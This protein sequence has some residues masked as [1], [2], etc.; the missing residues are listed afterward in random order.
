M[1][2]REH[3][4]AKG[5]PLATKTL[6]PLSDYLGHSF[7]PDCDY[8]DGELQERNLGELDHSDLQTRLIELLL[9]AGNKTHIRANSELRMQVKPT[10]FRIPD[11]CVLRRDAPREQIVRTPPILCIEVLSPDDTVKKTREQVRDFLEM[12]VREV[13]I[14]DPA[15]HTATLCSGS[16]ATEQTGGVLRIPDLPIEF[17]LAEIFSVLDE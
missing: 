14:L 2:R 8:I 6:I 7:R 11:V 17:S 3:N 4:A 10:R 13:W 9:R 5:L 16:I 15:T 1:T 12:G